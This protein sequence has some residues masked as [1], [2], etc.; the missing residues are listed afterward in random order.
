MNAS[1]EKKLNEKISVLPQVCG[2]FNHNN[3]EEE[4]NSLNR[5]VINTKIE[6]TKIQE[7]DV[8]INNQHYQG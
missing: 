7:E 2:Y 8:M 6:C 1:S 5:E 3:D 4:C